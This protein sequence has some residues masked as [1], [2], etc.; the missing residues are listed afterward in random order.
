MWWGWM[1]NAPWRSVGQSKWL[2]L[3]KE[4]DPRKHG[5]KYW[6]TTSGHWA[7]RR[8]NKGLKYLVHSC[9]QEVLSSTSW[10]VKAIR[11]SQEDWPTRPLR[12]CL[13]LSLRVEGKLFDP[14]VWTVMPHD[15]ETW[16]VKTKDVCGLEWNYTNILCWKCNV[17]VLVQQSVKHLEKN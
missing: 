17:S 5:A 15:S 2:E 14:F 10:S 7:F 6:R 4:G 1:S 13:S 9:M 12:W 8:D 11:F 3:L 16:A